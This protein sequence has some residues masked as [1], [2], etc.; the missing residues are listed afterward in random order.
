M[1]EQSLTLETAR[2]ENRKGSIAAGIRALAFNPRTDVPSKRP[3]GGEGSPRVAGWMG[4]RF[5]VNGLKTARPLDRLECGTAFGAALQIPAPGNRLDSL[6]GWIAVTYLSDLGA[7]SVSLRFHTSDLQWPL[8]RDRRRAGGGHSASAVTSYPKGAGRSQA[9]AEVTYR[10]TGQ[11]RRFQAT[12]G[13]DGRC[14]GGKGARVF[15]VLLDGKIG[16]TRADPLTGGSPPGPP[17]PDQ[18]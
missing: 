4:S 2:A 18:T 15:E 3:Q 11:H 12:I 16:S 6:P 14:P 10:L 9:E 13:I 5:R 17:R 7:G 1:N 8:R